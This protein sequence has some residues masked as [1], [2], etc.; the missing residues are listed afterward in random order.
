[1][2]GILAQRQQVKLDVSV[3]GLDALAAIRRRR[4]DL[5]LLDMHLPDID[6]LELLRHLKTGADTIDI[7][8]VIVSADALPT[9]VEA[10]LQAGAL[11]YLTKPVSVA[12]LLATIDE[13][14]GKVQTQFG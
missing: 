1:M 8:V 10:A 4:P 12:E 3:T 7:P 9:Q 5:I 13:V 2:R 11:R 6:G 14:L